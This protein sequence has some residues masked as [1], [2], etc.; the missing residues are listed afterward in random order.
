ME[1]ILGL[2]IGICL[3]AAC[4]FRVFVP[5]LG[6]SIAALTGHVHL[7]SGFEWLGTWPALVA[8]AT[9]TV[10]EIGTY[11]I[12]WVD[13]AMDALMTPVAIAAGVIVT[14]SLLGDM[15]P[16]LRWSLA[17]I[18]GGGVS[19]VVHAGTVAVRATS[20]GTTGGSTNF[21]VATAE[22]V[23]SILVTIL[24]ILL[25][26]LCLAAVVWIC[27]RM[28]TTIARSGLFKRLFAPRHDSMP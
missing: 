7:A 10:V 4:G 12:P 2:V 19:G 16:F 27:Y 24:A 5:L 18:A 23:G 6:M 20:S 28:I 14:A 8:F 26:F 9:A 3:S 22:L 17:V 1:L 21:L 15:S 11:Y 13:N 25:P